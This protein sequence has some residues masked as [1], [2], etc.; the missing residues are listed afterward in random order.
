M[1]KRDPVYGDSSPFTAKTRYDRQ[2]IW[3][4]DSYG[5]GFLEVFD[6][7][8]T[9]KTNKTKPVISSHV[10]KKIGVDLCQAIYTDKSDAELVDMIDF[11][12]QELIKRR[13]NEG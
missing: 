13:E 5:D 4:T 7:T 2:F 9:I 10:D 3:N 6:T 11:L 12:H 1:G 8:P